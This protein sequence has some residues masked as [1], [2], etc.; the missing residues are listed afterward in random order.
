MPC[1]RADS[2][3]QVK[4]VDRN[5]YSGDE[6]RRFELLGRGGQENR[7]FCNALGL[8]GGTPVARFILTQATRSGPPSQTWGWRVIFIGTIVSGLVS[9]YGCC[10]GTSKTSDQ[11]TRSSARSN[12]FHNA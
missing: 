8:S 12:A 10:R 5:T 3:R 11:F 2:R 7:P 6:W 9:Y 4:S 1:R